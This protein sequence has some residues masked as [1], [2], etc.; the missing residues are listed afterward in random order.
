M[1]LVSKNGERKSL[2]IEESR[3]VDKIVRVQ[4]PDTFEDQRAAS[5]QTVLGNLSSY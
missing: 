3:L 1:L 5:A 4:K 2:D